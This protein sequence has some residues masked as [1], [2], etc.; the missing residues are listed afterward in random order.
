MYIVLRLVNR[1]NVDGLLQKPVLYNVY[2]T[3]IGKQINADSLLQTPVLD[4]VCRTKGGKQI[5][6][7]GLLRC[8]YIYIISLFPHL[9]TSPPLP[10]LLLPVPNKS[11]GFYG[12]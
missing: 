9:H 10:H 12:R 1:F 3:K 8:R 11:Y 2:R 6:A 4:N 7:G 5:N